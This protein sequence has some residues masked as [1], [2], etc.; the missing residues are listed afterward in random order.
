MKI[1]SKVKI[2][3]IIYDV[4]IEKV[5]HNSLTEDKLWGHI[6]FN[7]CKIYLNGGLAEQ[8]LDEVFLHE[9]LHGIEHN[10]RINCKELDIDRLSH[11]IMAFLKDNNLLK[12]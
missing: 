1:P 3:G 8:A 9:V 12:E 6:E 11:G 4:D 7:E 2:G 5:V 10:F